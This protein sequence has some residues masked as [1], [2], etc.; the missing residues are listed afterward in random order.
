VGL[1]S[2]QYIKEAI[3]NVEEPIQEQNRGLPKVNQPLP[4][5]YHPELDVTAILDDD[6]TNL[7]QSYV[8][9][10]RWIV[11]LG[12]LDIYVH[13]AF[14][15][16]FLMRPRI[17]HLEAV[18]HVFGYLK[19]QNRSTIL[20]DEPFFFLERFRLVMTGMNFTEALK[21]M[22]QQ[23]LRHPVVKRCKLMYLLV[24]VMPEIS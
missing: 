1:S 16:S 6:D 15:S 2:Y 22:Y 17:G 21:R 7:Y 11:E 24:Q 20:F 18:Y 12:H 4:S 5:Y 8:S 13:V 23:M 9:V 3:I 14:S 19:G 10:L